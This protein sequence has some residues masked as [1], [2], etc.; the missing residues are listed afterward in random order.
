[1]LRIIAENVEKRFTQRAAF[2]PVSFEAS[3]GEI[4]AIT[5]QNGAGKTTLLKIVA[6]VLSPTKGSCVWK[7]DDKKLDYD[8]I[9]TI[10][11]YVG[12]YLELYDEL[13]AIEHV[14]FVADLKGIEHS[15]DSALEL[16][17]GFGLDP[18]VSKSDR[19]LRAYSSGMKQR[20]RIAM[21]FACQPKGLLLDEPTSTLDDTGTQLVLDAAQRAAANGAIVFIATN[22]ERERAIAQREIVIKP[23]V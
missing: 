7:Y 15:H 12:P 6:N 1:M 14:Q 5:G 19:R 4:I 13:T 11:G 10:I 3:P 2:H 20:V 9:R 17:T 16:L 8:G 18:A 22:D 21:A 23:K